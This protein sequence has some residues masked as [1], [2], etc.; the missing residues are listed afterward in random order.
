VPDG[1]VDALRG[2]GVRAV[3]TPKDFDLMAVM[4]RVLDVIGAPAAGAAPRAASA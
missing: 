1:D 2:L 3:F 4:D